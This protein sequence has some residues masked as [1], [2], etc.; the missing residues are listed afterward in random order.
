MKRILSTVCVLLG[1]AGLV[2]IPATVH[3]SPPTAV[4]GEYEFGDRV[5]V[6][7]RQA[8][9]NTII[10][11]VSGMTLAGDIEGS[12]V[13]ER[14]F[15]LHGD[16]KYNVKGI[17]TAIA[18]VGGRSG[19]YTQRVVAT[20]DLTTGTVQGTY[21][22]ISGTGGLANMRGQGT[23]TGISNVAGTYSGQVHFGPG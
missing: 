5:V 11:D 8:G 4:S 10:K 17:V 21:V 13:F 3:A 15:I 19:T 9:G 14:T 23:L 1:L 16:G 6:E 22:I 12:M 18:S 20:G 2:L 7:I